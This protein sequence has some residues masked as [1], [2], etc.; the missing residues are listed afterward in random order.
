MQDRICRID[1]NLLHPTAGPY[2]RVTGGRL[3]NRGPGI[4]SSQ[5]VENNG[6]WQYHPGCPALDLGD[7]S[8]V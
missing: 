4:A 1:E 7:N 6:H 8:R 5:I 3:E 2:I